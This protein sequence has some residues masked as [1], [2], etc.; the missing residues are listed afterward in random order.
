MLLQDRT[1]EVQLET[2]VTVVA[3]SKVI[4][5]FQASLAAERFGVDRLAAFPINQRDRA[6]AV[7]GNAVH[8]AGDA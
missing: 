7:H 6:V 4:E 1:V 8:R 3:V 2:V 5:R